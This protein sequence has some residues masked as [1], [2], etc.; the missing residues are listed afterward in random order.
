MGTTQYVALL[1]AINVGGRTVKMDALRGA[2][3]A[4]GLTSVETFIASGNVIFESRAGAAGL[5][6]KIEAHLRSVLGYEVAAFV[7]S[8][9]ELAAAAAHCETLLRKGE[10]AH[11]GFLKAPVGKDG[12]T[13][14]AAYQTA[15][16]R[17]AFAGRE[18]FWLTRAGIGQSKFSNAVFERIIKSPATFRNVTTVRKLA[19]VLEVSER[20]VVLRNGRVV[21]EG[22]AS[23]FDAEALMAMPVRENL[24]NAP[25]TATTTGDS[26]SMP[27]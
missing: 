17:F 3:E 22:P 19:E 5:E 26:S 16:E 14:V 15:D 10:G 7:R 13:R 4:I 12:Q 1:R 27:L 20:V 23:G 2:C 8:V 21:A 18:I 6:T 11:I 24:R 25:T 9:P